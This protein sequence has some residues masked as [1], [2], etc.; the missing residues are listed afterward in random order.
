MNKF[1]PSLEDTPSLYRAADSAST[2]GQ[3]RFLHATKTRLIL[4]SLAAASAITS[5]RVGGTEVLALVSAVAFAGALIA[6]IYLALTKPEKLWYEGRAVAES[7]KTLMWRFMVGGAALGIKEPKLA[8][9]DHL[10]SRYREIANDLPGLE[11][12]PTVGL[13]DQI[14]EYMRKV[15]ALHLK[16]RMRY[17]IKG[18][19]DNQI[20]WYGQRSRWNRKHATIWVTLLLMLEL[21]GLIAAILRATG[22]LPIDIMGILSA[23]AAGG[24]AWV[25]AKQYQALAAAYAVAY[26]ELAIIKTGASKVLSEEAWATYV[27]AA[28]DA[29]SRE[30]T[31][32][33]ASRPFA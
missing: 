9:E 18:R 19:L 5:W 4:L 20:D 3:R 8:A 15:R 30:H 6:E 26:H 16:E 14:T 1:N 28:E 27:A 17:Y 12:I 32:W 23:V 25:Q 29:I 13:S 21:A 31:L 24:I 10:L 2:S 11:L 33:R 7:A 22:M